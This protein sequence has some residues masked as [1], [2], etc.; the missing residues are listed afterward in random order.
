MYVG[1]RS[2]LF[3]LHPLHGRGPHAPVFIL[4]LKMGPP[5]GNHI[6]PQSISIII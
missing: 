6:V 2:L 3:Q 4:N 5:G 1:T